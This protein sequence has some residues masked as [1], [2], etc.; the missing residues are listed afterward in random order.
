MVLKN[1][2]T[3]MLF[4]HREGMKKAPDPTDIIWENFRESSK[5]TKKRLRIF[6][7]YF[8]LGF[9]FLF[10]ILFKLGAQYMIR[11]RVYFEK[12]NDSKIC[13]ALNKEFKY[14]VIEREA[15]D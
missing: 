4:G 1:K 11:D 7:L 12:N 15:A 6:T 2:N 10:S 14:R 9:F 13:S 3:L 5:K 8:M